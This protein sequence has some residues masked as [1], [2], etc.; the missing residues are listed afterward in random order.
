MVRTGAQYIASL[1]DGRTVYVNGERVADVTEHPAFRGAVRSIAHLYDLAASPEHRDVMTFPSPSTGEP[2][3]KSFLVPRTPEDLAARRRAHRLWADA[4]FGLMGRSPDHVPGFITGFA[5]RPDL[6][7]R[8]GQRFADNVVRYH[9]WLRDTDL[10]AAYVIAPPHIDRSRPAHQ[11]ED[12]HLYAGVVEERGDGIVVSGAQMLGTGGAIANEMFMSCI[13]PL[14]AGDESY[15]LSLAVPVASPG[16]RL[17]VRRP[18]AE[19]ATSV[20]RLP[21]VLPLRRDR[22]A[23]G[24]RPGLRSLG[25][26]VRVQGRRADAGAVL[27][28]AGPR[29]R[30]PPG[31]GALHQQ[32][33]VPGGGGAPHRGVHR[34]RQGAANPDHARRARQL[35]RDGLGLVLASEAECVHD[36][37]GFVYPNPT[38]LYANNWLEAT[39]YQTM[40]TYVRELAGGGLLQLPSSYKDYLNP[41]ISAD[42]ERFVRSPGLKSVERTK[43]YKLAWDLVGS[44]FAGRHQQYELFYAGARAQTTAVRAYRAF[45]FAAA[46]AMVER[47]LAGYDLPTEI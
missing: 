11:Q 44:E 27:R 22:R 17:I 26:G 8:Q 2:V 25:A 7:A 21:A 42:L 37:R 35:L 3:N 14:V 29:A 10:Y 19:T 36:E 38:Y 31:A 47:C 39:Y 41:D 13:V 20:F 5:M 28:D 16:L 33:A 32:G 24:L 30:E 43:L 23:G 45:D 46:R 1:R 18:Y 40:L 15:A 4:T 12:P 34:R 9:A 6:F